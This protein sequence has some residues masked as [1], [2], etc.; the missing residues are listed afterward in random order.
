LDDIP[1]ETI[2][3]SRLITKDKAYSGA[4]GELVNMMRIFS[5]SETMSKFEKF[6]V[7]LEDQSMLQND[8]SADLFKELSDDMEG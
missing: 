3:A 6:K 7:S 5:I 8:R 2:A 1:K 4:S